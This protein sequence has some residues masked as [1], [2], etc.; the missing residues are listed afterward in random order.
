MTI[1]LPPDLEHRLASHARASGLAMPEFVR[2]TLAY[3]LAQQA[4]QAAAVLEGLGAPGST[5]T[6]ADLAGVRDLI[7]DA[8]NGGACS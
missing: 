5:L 1:E 6:P 3:A 2:E 4:E 7:G 8:R